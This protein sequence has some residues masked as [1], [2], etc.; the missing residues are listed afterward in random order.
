MTEALGHRYFFVGM[1]PSSFFPSV[2][3]YLGLVW[4]NLFRG[5]RGFLCFSFFF[6]SYVVSMLGPLF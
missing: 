3:H 2:L 6:F 1:P 4:N 5:I